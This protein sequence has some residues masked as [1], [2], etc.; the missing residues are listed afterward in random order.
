MKKKLVIVVGLIIWTLVSVFI[1]SL[2]QQ[3]DSS[4]EEEYYEAACLE[5]D[6]IRWYFDSL[7]PKDQTEFSE[8]YDDFFQGLDKGEMNTKFI[9]SKDFLEQYCWCY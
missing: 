1:G 8:K 7:E 3:K 5:S 9:K 2:I 6:F 4:K